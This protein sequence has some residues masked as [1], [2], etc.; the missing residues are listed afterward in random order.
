MGDEMDVGKNRNFGGQ[1]RKLKRPS[2][3][4][5]RGSVEFKNDGPDLYYNEFS[6]S[7]GVGKVGGWYEQLSFKQLCRLISMLHF[8]TG[9]PFT[10]A[11]TIHTTSSKLN[12]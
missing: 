4:R 10:A 7:V 9:V 1:K 2:L 6:V 8:D 11:A 3:T 12:R 5:M